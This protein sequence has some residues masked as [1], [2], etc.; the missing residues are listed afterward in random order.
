MMNR[1]D[2]IVAISLFS[3]CGGLDIG[4][5]LAGVPVVACIE[6]D[7]DSI[8]T[9]SLNPQFSRASLFLEDVRNFTKKRLLSLV[10]KDSKKL[11]V[12][13]GP[14]CQPFSKAGYWITNNKRKID[15]DPRNMVSEFFRVVND[16]QPSGFIFEN[17]ESLLHPTNK[18]TID[19]ILELASK[20]KY[21]VF[22]LAANALDYGVPQKR[23]RIFIIGSK[24]KFK[25]GDAPTKTHANPNVALDIGLIPHESVKKHLKPYEGKRFFEPEEVVKG[26]TY[27]TDL[28][29]I[30]P[31]KNYMVLS[32]KFT[33]GKRFWNFLLKLHPDLPS[34]TIAAQPG[35]WVGPFH[36]QNRRLRIPE[37][38]ALQ[39]F[40]SDYKFFGSRRSVQRQIGNAVP[41]KMAKAVTEFLVRNI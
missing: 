19:M 12:I 32:E 18:H 26:K 27:G 8:K 22:F 30:P 7:S 40:P 21:N 36:W 17:V 25:K 2:K 13:G 4:A 3:G 37:I 34:W 5:H 38:A 1:K 11:I 9:L 28:T 23:K 31:G 14:P 6:H 33:K 39:T 24:N 20:M 35:P 15:K 29:K 10:P 16:L 41:V